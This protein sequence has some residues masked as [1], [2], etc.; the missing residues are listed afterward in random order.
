[1]TAPTVHPDTEATEAGGQDRDRRHDAT[2][3]PIRLFE[4]RRV[5]H[6]QRQDRRERNGTLEYPRE[7]L[8]SGLK[9]ALPQWLKDG[10]RTPLTSRPYGLSPAERDAYEERA[11]IIEYDGGQP[12]A[13]AEDFAADEVLRAR[14][15]NAGLD[16]GAAAATPV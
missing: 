3:R 8:L 13:R 5:D 2:R 11:A 9:D 10:N 6:Q 4:N 15:R 7:A 1:M 14:R 12:R 16:G